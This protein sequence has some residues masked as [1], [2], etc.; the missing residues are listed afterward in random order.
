MGHR[1]DLDLAWLW[2]WYRPAATALILPLA[3]EPPYAAGEA[4]KKDK[5]QKKEKELPGAWQEGREGGRAR[6]YPSL[7][8]CGWLTS[9]R[10]LT[11]PLNFTFKSPFLI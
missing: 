2:L 5:R 6:L 4:L 9:R 11:R 1:H 3:W 8:L 10:N 7:T